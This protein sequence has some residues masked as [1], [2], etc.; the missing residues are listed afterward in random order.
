MATLARS[1]HVDPVIA[2]Y[3]ARLVDATRSASEVRLGVSVRGAMGLM[4]AARV[5]AA[6]NAR[7][8]VTPDDVKSI[9]Y[10]VLR[11]RLATTYEAEAEEMM[12]FFL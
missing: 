11:H 3:V 5:F 9:G 4:R 2:D 8:Y 10:D 12:L 7:H 6:L 1:V